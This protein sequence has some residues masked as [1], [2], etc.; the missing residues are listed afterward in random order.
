MRKCPCASGGE[1]VM[2]EVTIKDIARLCGVG[3]STVSRAINDHPDINPAT[4]KQIQ[5]T[6]EQ[7]GYIPNNSA[8][9]L[10]RTES[11]AVAILVKGITNPLFSS[12][13]RVLDEKLKRFKFDMLVQH[14]NYDED[15]VAV[16]L[17]LIKEKRLKGIVFLG[18][19]YYHPEGELEKINVPFVLGTVGS[20][21]EDEDLSRYSHV[22]LDDEKESYKAVEYLI[23]KGH[24]DIAIISAEER[25]S[26]VGRLRM[27]GYKR[28]L[29]AYQIPE[30]KELICPVSDEIEHYTMT[31]GYM[32]TKK[33]IESGA[34]FSAVFAFSDTIAAGVY[35][36]VHEAG[37]RIP[38]DVSVVGFDGSELGDYL[39]PKLTSVAQ[40]VSKMADAIINQL[41]DMIDGRCGNRTQ[42]FEGK[43]LEKESVRQIEHKS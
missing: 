12:M 18:L 24:R 43:L 17:E 10:K 4:K 36:A 39:Q 2:S 9:N 20:I 32:T 34:P 21:F 28:A 22:A 15:E 8:R 40:P 19:N 35:R 23:R 42:I 16:A 25:D 27:Q 41:Y 38:E 1:A 37:L 30:K 29:A 31:N 6:I 11:N 14:I 3:I 33:L 13:I 5:E 26:S 7:Y